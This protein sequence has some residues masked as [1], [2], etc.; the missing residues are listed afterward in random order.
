MRE[1]SDLRLIWKLSSMPRAMSRSGGL[2]LDLSVNR[3]ANPCAAAGSKRVVWQWS[4]GPQI[5]LGR[6]AL[7]RGDAEMCV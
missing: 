4:A 2:A 1:R 5:G 7:P 3:E 6:S